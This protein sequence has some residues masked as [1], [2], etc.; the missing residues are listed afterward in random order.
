MEKYNGSKEY[1]DI[2][3][4]E[5]VEKKHNYFTKD[6]PLTQ[7]QLAFSNHYTLFE[8]LFFKGSRGRS[9]EVGCGRGN[10]SLYFAHNGWQTSLLDQSESAISVAKDNFASLGFE[11]E[12]FTGDANSL[13]FDDETFDTTFSVG[14]LEHF[15][16]V[17]PSIK[18]QLRVLKKG[19]IFIG[20]VVP[21]RKVNIQT[22]AK[23]FNKGLSLLKKF[24]DRDVD[25]FKKNKNL[26]FRSDYNSKYYLNIMKNYDF[27]EIGHFGIFPVPSISYS[28]IYPF[29][30]L[31][32]KLEKFAVLM[33]KGLLS[34]RSIFTETP[35]KCSE[36]W[37]QAFVVWGR[38]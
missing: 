36:F 32:E 20:Y 24:V 6:I 35:W 4:K 5:R 12:F 34:T 38:K 23:P 18:E 26:L 25:S 30:P 33:E 17:K 21:E 27:N 9:L 16:D 22:F 19:G 37:G 14:L 29:T 2:N 11:G 8:K 1:F 7:M 15:K 10:L 28:E 31:P 13:Q 3:W